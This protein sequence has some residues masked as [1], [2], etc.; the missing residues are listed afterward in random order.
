MVRN[1]NFNPKIMAKKKKE[2]KSLF[3]YRL[4]WFL[5]KRYDKRKTPA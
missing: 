3:Y 4:M 5:W 1:F 2:L